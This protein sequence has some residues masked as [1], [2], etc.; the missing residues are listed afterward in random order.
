MKRSDPK[1][2]SSTK[3]KQVHRGFNNPRGEKDIPNHMDRSN[4]DIETE[5]L[6]ERS[7]QKINDVRL[8][9]PHI[10]NDKSF[11]NLR[12]MS[13]NEI[14][15]LYSEYRNIDNS[16]QN[17]SNSQ[18]Y[19]E[20]NNS[21]TIDLEIPDK[22]KDI[23]ENYHE[24]NS[25]NNSSLNSSG[26]NFLEEG[27]K[28]LHKNK[29]SNLTNS[30]YKMSNQKFNSNSNDSY[31][32]SIHNSID[33]SYNKCVPSKHN[34]KIK[35]SNFKQDELS[36][37]FSSSKISLKSLTDSQNKNKSDQINYNKT[38]NHSSKNKRKDSLKD[39]VVI[40]SRQ[41]INNT[42]HNSQRNSNNSESFINP[43]KISLKLTDNDFYHQESFV[44]LQNNN[45]DFF[46]TQTDHFNKSGEDSEDSKIFAN[47]RY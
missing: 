8:E 47:K 31:S 10:L 41:S 15:N 36:F 2:T 25:S 27:K 5:T 7:L 17:D 19:M 12:I 3:S 42:L 24:D 18:I 44:N 46:Q 34:S 37:G 28:I 1:K 43:D 32:H 4:K 40:G 11:E 16:L 35:I 20:I 29:L 30:N 21:K 9:S 22:L 38:S 13:D 33:N 6:A 45:S 39:P 26:K 14:S 23:I